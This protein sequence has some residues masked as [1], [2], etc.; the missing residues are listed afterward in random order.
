MASQAN[1]AIP[2]RTARQERRFPV[3]LPALLWIGEEAR[4]VRLRDLS[5]AGALAEAPTAP[6]M[7]EQ[8]VLRVERLSVEARVA[9]VKGVRFG[10]AFEAPIR[11]TDLLVLLGR[12]RAQ[13]PPS[14]SSDSR[15]VSPL[16]PQPR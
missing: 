9:W 5:R 10:L 2:D 4:V 11:A 13:A 3:Y 6:P 14:T 16:P 12:S 1:I 7:G 15:S 8:V